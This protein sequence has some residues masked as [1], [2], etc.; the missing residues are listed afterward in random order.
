MI[1]LVSGVEHAPGN[2]DGFMF[3]YTSVSGVALPF[4]RDPSL[5]T[6]GSPIGPP[7]LMMTFGSVG[8]SWMDL[9]LMGRLID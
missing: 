7:G 2:G 3:A 5:P 8:C 1:V 6:T 4:F 9:C